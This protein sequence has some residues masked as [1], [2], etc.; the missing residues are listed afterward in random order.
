METLELFYPQISA[1]AG[2]YTFDKGVEIEVY[3]SK[4]SYFDWAKIRFTE[5]F[6]PKISLKKKD[7]AAIELGYDDI[8]EEVF[9]GYVSKPYNGG[10]FTD[11]VT[12]KDEMLLLEET[13]INDTFLDTTPQE[14]ISYFLG[15]AG[16]SKMKLSSQGYPK[17]KRLPIRQMSV[18]EAINA[19]HAAWNT[20][21]PF[22][23]S[24]GVFYWGE[25]PEQSKAFDA[26]PAW[27]D[28]T[29]QVAINRV[30]NFLNQSKTAEKWG[31]NVSFTIEKN[32]G[33]EGEVSISGFGGAYE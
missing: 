18:I 5:Q 33:Y 7:P 6:Q 22:F 12:L 4:T 23:F 28:I 26:S 14:M 29:A 30:Y 10:G 3:S 24:G 16:V 15:K 2:P 19:V 11:E 31:V 1:R 25:K 20:K 21:Q 13:Q 27:E 8:F 17:R 9:T 32:E